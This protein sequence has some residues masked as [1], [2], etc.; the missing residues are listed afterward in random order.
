[1]EKEKRCRWMLMASMTVFGTIGLFRRWIPLP[2]GAIAMARGLIGAAFLLLVLWV[3]KEKIDFSAMKGQLGKLL[4]SGA[5]IGLNWVALFEA[6][7][8][9][10]VS[11]A[12]VCYYMAPIIVMA[13]SPWLLR[14]KLSLRKVLC[15]LT[16]LLGAALV[17][18]ILT[19]TAQ[20]S[21]HLLGVALG[22]LAAVMYATVVLVNKRIVSVKA[23]DRTILQLAAAGGVLIPYVALTERVDPAVFSWKTALLMLIVCVLHTGIAYALYFASLEG[24]SGQMAALYSYVD[25]IVA[26]LASAIVLQERMS[27]W[28]IVGSVL[29]LGAAIISELPEK[30]SVS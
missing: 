26:V 30:T 14:E 24:V 28:G 23:F 25:P 13:L 3:K 10:S 7:R 11:V 17:S 21:N 5:L 8:F 29:V 2:S 22:L 9:T 18:G 12:T 16:A 1:M 20:G 4:F 6:F 27:G 19:G 15:V